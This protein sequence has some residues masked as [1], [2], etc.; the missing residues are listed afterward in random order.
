M[1]LKGLTA[2]A[3]GPILQALLQIFLLPGK[4]GGVLYT[5]GLGSV[6]NTDQAVL[7]TKEQQAGSSASNP[8]M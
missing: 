5:G 6:F 8:H 1:E 7:F 4:I 2:S 3:H